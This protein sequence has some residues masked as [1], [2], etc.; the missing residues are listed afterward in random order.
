MAKYKLVAEEQGWL[1]SFNNYWG[2]KYSNN[3]PV[4]KS[5]ELNSYSIGAET[6]E[7]AV[8]IFNQRVAQGPAIELVEVSDD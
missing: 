5:Q 2:T 7:S 1:D 6:L 3:E 8:D 4:F